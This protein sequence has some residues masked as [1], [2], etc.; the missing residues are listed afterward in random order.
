MFSGWLEL[1][2]CLVLGLCWVVAIGDGGVGCTAISVCVCVCLCVCVGGEGAG[3]A[4][5]VARACVW[6][7][8]GKCNI[9]LDND[10]AKRNRHTCDASAT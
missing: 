8:W 9:D 5:G 7:F 10:H 3:A 6:V 2:W 1:R 4:E